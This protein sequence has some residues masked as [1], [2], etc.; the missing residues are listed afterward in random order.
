MSPEPG[1]VTGSEKS[2]SSSLFGPGAQQR[3]PVGTPNRLKPP[4][5]ELEFR[6]AGVTLETP[7][8][9]ARPPR[10]SGSPGRGETLPKTVPQHQAW[11][12]AWGL[13]RGWAMSSDSHAQVP[14]LVAQNVTLPGS[15]EVVDVLRQVEVTTVGPD[16]CGGWCST[17]ADRH[18]DTRGGRR[19]KVKTA[20]D[21]A[22]DAHSLG[23]TQT[24]VTDLRLPT[25][26]W[27]CVWSE[28]PARRALLC[29]PGLGTSSRAS[30]HGVPSGGRGPF[31][32]NEGCDQGKTQASLR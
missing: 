26:V 5:R 16:Q 7:G 23:R 10:T 30:P 11:P 29:G 22:G 24:A 1:P 19:V 13:L 8:G 3:D 9:R 32:G 14:T 25:R 28:P 21:P 20:V 31:G 12:S 4:L 15:R 2:G 6:A 18:T 27:G 17:S